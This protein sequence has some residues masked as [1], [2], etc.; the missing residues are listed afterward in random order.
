MRYT[1]R[2]VIQASPYHTR[3]DVWID[4]NNVKDLTRI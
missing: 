4:R 1:D 3:A 2:E